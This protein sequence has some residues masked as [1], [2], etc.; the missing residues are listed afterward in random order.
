M[1]AYALASVS[2]FAEEVDLD[3]IV[4]G[5]DFRDQNLSEVSSSVAI[6]SEKDIYDK[7]AQSFVETIA[8]VP[9]VNF[10]SGASKA[11]YIQIRGIGE[12]SQ[13]VT[14]INPSVGIMVDGIDFSQSALGV[15]MFD[16]KQI[17]VLRGPQGTT[18]GANGMAGVINVESNDPTNDAN[19]HV[20]ATVGNYNTKA[21]GIALNAPIVEDKLLAR[22]S[23]YKNTSDG[24][25]TNSYLGRDDTN[26]I[27]ELTARA[28]FKWFVTENHTI[29]LTLMHVD[30]DNGYDS[31]TLD[32]TRDTH[33]DQP[34]KDTQ[35]TDAFAL[36]ST[37]QVNDKMHLVSSLSYSKSDLEY[38]Y[39]EDWSY[40]GEFDPAWAYSSFD[41]YLRDRRQTDIDVRMVS[42]EAGRIFNGSTD[43]TMGVYYK[44]YSEEMTRN[45]TY[46]DTPFLSQ[47]DTQNTAVYGQLDTHFTNK[48]TMIAGLRI[49]KW[50]SQYSDSYDVAI[51]TDEVLSGG[52]LGLNYQAEA[53]MLYYVTISK[54]YKPGGVNSDYRLTS[55]A[56]QYETETLW[57]LDAGLN[58]SH[59]DNKV[60]SR[61]NLF[62]GK[63]KDQQVKSSVVQTR[64]DGS[65]EFID[66]LANAAEGTYYGLESQIDYFPME[67]LHLFTSLG[68]LKA[69]FDEYNDPN[70]GTIDVNGR[71]PANSPEY[72]Y[73]V[74]FDYM[75]LDAWTFKANVE[76]KGSYYFSNRHNEKSD[77]YA[78]LNASLEYT[79]GSFTAS[80]WTRNLTDEEYFVRGFGSFGNNPSKF[81]ETELYTQLGAPRTAGL[82]LSYDF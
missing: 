46:L 80:I 39:D 27:D 82:T 75:F 78:L 74:G 31:W 56:K 73:N 3:P 54:G 51:N 49:E 72:Q 9:N 70:P 30:V 32:N 10:S 58:S 6:I 79:T 5:A 77:P 81:Y 53:D 36:K 42:D 60:K 47:Y 7:A 43:W 63:R 57:N 40:D 76:G 18:F 15:T 35:L 13:F 71:A 20:E 11:K 1:A 17:E 61:L 21:V 62:Y 69:K 33:S 8:A 38:S 22:F 50:E 29:D 45:Y 68:F 24:Y 66:Y 12:R 44:D 55:D 26:N 34:G 4:V 14:P 65:T 37:Y 48:L 67:G 41:Q 28:K 2:A 64:S 59:F 19:G 23:L 16:L 25:M 52:K